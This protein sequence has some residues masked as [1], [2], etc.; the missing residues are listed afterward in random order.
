MAYKPDSLELITV[1]AAEV[2]LRLGATDLP[3]E[4]RTVVHCWAGG[5]GADWNLDGALDLV[6][7]AERIAWVPMGL[8]VEAVWNG[9]LRVVVFDSVV[10]P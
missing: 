3:D 4:G 2:A 1:E 7:K 6:R 10:R 5:F 8:G 9:R